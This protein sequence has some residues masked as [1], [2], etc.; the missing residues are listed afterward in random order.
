MT[1]TG[2]GS[3]GAGAPTRA[4]VSRGTLIVAVVIAVVVAGIAG[5]AVGWKVEQNRVKDDVKNV[6]PVGTVTAVDDGSLTI[7]LQTASGTRT[8]VITKGTVVDRARTGELG[9]VTKG[10]TV[11]VKGF[12]AD[13]KLQASEIV[14]LPRGS[15]LGASG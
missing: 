3:Q 13:G 4:G 8:Y 9:D 14:V 7:S 5:V 15:K 11:L 1:E 2:V 10:S 12:T 6:R